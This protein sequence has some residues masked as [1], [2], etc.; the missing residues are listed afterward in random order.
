MPYSRVPVQLRILPYN[1]HPA[2]QRILP[3]NSDPAQQRS[4]PYNS[5]SYSFCPTQC[6]PASKAWPTVCRALH[7]R[8]VPGPCYMLCHCMHSYLC[9]H[10]VRSVNCIVQCATVP[11]LM[12]SA[13]MQCAVP[14]A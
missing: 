2:Q 13:G 11:V 3:Y 5:D 4:L 7:A 14:T 9:W 10:A 1:S 6:P 8:A 12:A